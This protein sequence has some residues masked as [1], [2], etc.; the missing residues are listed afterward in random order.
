MTTAPHRRFWMTP[1][2]MESLAALIV[3]SRD[4]AAIARALGCSTKTVSRH[5][6]RIAHGDERAAP[7]RRFEP[8]PLAA[9]AEPVSD[10]EN[11]QGR[12]RN[13]RSDAHFRDA[14][15][16]A[17]G[18]APS[19]PS[20]TAGTECPRPMAAANTPTGGSPAGFAA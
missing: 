18:R 3:T 11:E 4:D 9:D 15:M 5:R 17:H 1:A 7:T 8:T 6:V 20:P 10:N 13:I 12:Q 19:D 16:Q 14:M 2:R